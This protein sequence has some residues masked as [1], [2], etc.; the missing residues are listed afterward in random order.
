MLLSK[1]TK[2]MKAKTIC[3]LLGVLWMSSCSI[4][5][6]YPNAER[7]L[8][9][10][11]TPSHENKVDVFF[12]NE[13]IKEEYVKVKVLEVRGT[14]NATYQNMLNR[15]KEVGQ[16]AGVDAILIL[17]NS[18]TASFTTD[19]TSFEAF[20]EVLTGEEI[21]DNVQPIVRQKLYGLGVKY[22]KNIN[23]LDQIRKK[24][25]VFL[26]EGND[27]VEVASASLD[28]QGNIEKIEGD[29]DIWFEMYG[30][31]L[32]HLLY[33]DDPSWSFF[34]E[35]KRLVRLKKSGLNP[36]KKVT[37]H[38][39]MG[40]YLAFMVVH[41]YY[42]AEGYQ[43]KRKSII[44]F[45]YDKKTKKIRGKVIKKHDKSE[46]YEELIYNENQVLQERILYKVSGEN[47]TPYLSESYDYFDNSEL[48]NLLDN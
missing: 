28:L 14:D 40:N 2:S 22:V 13:E 39:G 35:S 21:P 42:F 30:Y 37:L 6:Q 3:L 31:S 27:K 5:Q 12:P 25:K 32:D 8:T 46:L 16:E 34:R 48:V 43:R 24:R 44:D 11:P 23:Y 4:Y 10:I 36:A 26:H 9:P 15:L 41:D 17:K 29:R 18:S 47:K 33:E 7:N 45:L 20:T 1:K 38:Y 19:E